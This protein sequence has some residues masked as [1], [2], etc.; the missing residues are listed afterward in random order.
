MEKVPVFVIVRNV[1]AGWSAAVGVDGKAVAQRDLTIVG[2]SSAANATQPDDTARTSEN[3]PGF[4][5]VLPLDREMQPP[6]TQIL[7]LGYLAGGH[8]YA[9]TVCASTEG[10]SDCATADGAASPAKP[11]ASATPGA[12]ILKTAKQSADAGGGDAGSSSPSGSAAPQS[13]PS[14]VAP[15]HRIIAVN[16]VT[17]HSLHYLGLRAGVGG[18]YSLG[19]FQ[20]LATVPGSQTSLVR[21]QFGDMQPSV[22]LLV[23]IYPSGRDAIEMPPR[24]SWGPVGGLDLL[25]I[26]AYPRFCAG[27][28]VDVYGF[29]FTFLTSVERTAYVSDPA[30]SVLLPASAQI[31]GVWRPGFSLA[32]TTD[33]DIFEAIGQKYINPPKFPAI[34]TPGAN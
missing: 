11:A 12:A 18:V 13:A 17:V 5:S 20:S 14:P 4:H 10:T 22:P 7:S 9:V 33:F 25:S 27:V 26:G 24:F 28:V 19:E 2:V 32:L 16:S 8:R 3:Q 34:S 31:D 6:S 21:K 1:P 29:G 30:N 23:A 15:T